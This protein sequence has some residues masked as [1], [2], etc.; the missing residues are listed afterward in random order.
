MWKYTYG[1]YN[2]PSFDFGIILPGWCCECEEN[3]MHLYM[4]KDDNTD[5]N[6]D[7]SHDDIELWEIDNCDTWIWCS[8]C[9]V[10]IKERRRAPFFWENSPFIDYNKVGDTPE[11]LDKYAEELDNWAKE[12]SE[13][14]GMYE[15]SSTKCSLCGTIMKPRTGK[16]E[17][18]MECPACHWGWIS[19][20]P[21]P[22]TADQTIYQIKLSAN[23]QASQNTLK[24]ISHITMQNYM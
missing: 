8:N 21:D 10:F 18:G 6:K 24:I 3:T 15:K 9:H 17:A 11:Y 14:A 20:I 4:H 13:K 16:N 2:L 23:N 19:Y 22:I 1:L 7:N 5:H 12:L